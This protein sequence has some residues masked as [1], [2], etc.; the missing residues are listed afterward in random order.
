MET[1]LYIRIIKNGENIMVPFENLE[2]VVMEPEVIPIPDAPT[3]IL[4]VGWYEN[5]LIPYICMRERD[6]RNS[7]RCGVL[8]RTQKGKLIGMTA[9]VV[10][11]VVEAEREAV[12]VQEDL[13]KILTGGS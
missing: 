12:E 13:M 8:L 3:E 2:T 5:Q 10:G 11:E 7:F 1:I 6:E 9:D 4:G